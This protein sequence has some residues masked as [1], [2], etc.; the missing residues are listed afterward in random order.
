MYW[1]AEGLFREN[2]NRVFDRLKKG[3]LLHFR[4]CYQL[5]GVA[6]NCHGSPGYRFSNCYPVGSSLRSRM[7][8]RPMEAAVR[9]SVRRKVGVGVELKSGTTAEVGNRAGSSAAVRWPLG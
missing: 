6:P 9:L 4:I 2:R 3:Q 8:G 5:V 7:S 1:D